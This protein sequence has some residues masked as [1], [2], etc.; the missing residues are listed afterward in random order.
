MRTPTV[1][2]WPAYGC[3][4]DPPPAQPGVYPKLSE[5]SA[6]PSYQVKTEPPTLRERSPTRSSWVLQAFCLSAAKPSSL[7]IR[8]KDD[9]G[10]G[11][12][13]RKESSRCWHTP[14]STL[15][16]HLEEVLGEAGR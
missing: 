10:E 8:R 14:L 4:G 5:V 1:Q 15:G 13:E 6:Q 2:L 9:K 12:G 7:R 16:G 3:R 11:R